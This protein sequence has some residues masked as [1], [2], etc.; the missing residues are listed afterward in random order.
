MEIKWGEVLFPVLD[1]K[2]HMR[3]DYVAFIL[4]CDTFIKDIKG[5]GTSGVNNILPFLT[6]ICEKDNKSKEEMR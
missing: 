5:L 1:L 6:I 4:G 3:W 2:G